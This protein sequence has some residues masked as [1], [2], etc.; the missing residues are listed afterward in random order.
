MRIAVF[1]GLGTVASEFIVHAMAAGHFV[2]C[3]L[4]EQD[5]LADKDLESNPEYASVLRIVRGA[6]SDISKY[7][8]TL[9]DT[10]AVLVAFDAQHTPAHHWAYQQKMV[11]L[12][13]QH[14]HVSRLVVV[15]SHGAGSS[16]RLLDWSTW[17]RLNINQAKY[18]LG[19]APAHNTC[20][21]LLAQ[22]TAQEQVVINGEIPQDI[23]NDVS[24][25]TER[26]LEW[27]ILRPGVLVDGPATGTYLAS[28]EH[29]F[30][31]Y[32]SP[33]DVADCA[34]KALEDEMDVGKCFSIAYSAR[35]A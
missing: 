10:T 4:R 34:L 9:R 3:F 30:G 29:V 12:A 28:E 2:S 32:I 5:Q 20:W 1:G 31:G 13:M 7:Q 27:T 35:V 19:L 6:T 24:T 26:G 15:T 14:E 17:V 18:L 11:Q 23:L 25:N 22:Y 8:E 16:R 33:A 21:S